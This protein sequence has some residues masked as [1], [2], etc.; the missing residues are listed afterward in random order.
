MVQANLATPLAPRDPA[1][2]ASAPYISQLSA[3]M[4]AAVV[5]AGLMAGVCL[6]LR[7]NR[8]SRSEGSE[9]SD[10]AALSKPRVGGSNPRDDA[11]R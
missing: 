7:K 9:L 3:A 1:P 6:L 10:A 11:P 5:A 4:I 8:H 2:A